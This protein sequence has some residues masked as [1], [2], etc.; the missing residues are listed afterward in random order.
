VARNDRPDLPPY[1]PAKVKS[2]H[3]WVLKTFPDGTTTMEQV[4]Q[5]YWVIVLTGAHIYVTM[6]MTFPIGGGKPKFFSVLKVDGEHRENCAT[7]EEFERLWKKIERGEE[8]PEA[9]P[10]TTMPVL[11]PSATEG[12]PTMV[13]KSYEAICANLMSQGGDQH[14][15]EEIV[16]VYR[17][18]DA[19]II[20]ANIPVHRAHM[21]LTH[22]PTMQRIKG[23]KGVRQVGYILSTGV[24]TDEGGK[25]NTFSGAKIMSMIQSFLGKGGARGGPGTGQVKGGFSEIGG[26]ANSVQVR[27]GTVRRV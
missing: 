27:Q 18:G 24:V 2:W 10:W 7:P 3:E 23:S 4:R 22:T 16:S 17:E 12:I 5:R 9:E 11:P 6:E 13:T 8:E 14:L 20:E 19:W 1:I 21:K 25:S 15:R 26:A